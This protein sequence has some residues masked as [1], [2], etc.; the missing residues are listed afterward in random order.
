VTAQEL[1]AQALQDYQDANNA[2]KQGD[3]ATYKLK[4]DDAQRKTEQAQ[5]IL[6]GGAPADTTTTTTSTTST[7][8]SG[9][10]A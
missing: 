1:L 10:S 9:A 5:Q 6:S 7:T 4:I 3:L 8:L 2:L